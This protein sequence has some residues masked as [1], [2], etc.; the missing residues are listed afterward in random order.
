MKEALFLKRNKER[1]L[2]YEKALY[3]IEQVPADTLSQMYIALTD[4]LAYAQTY[5]PKSKSTRYLNHLAAQIHQY[6]YRNKKEKNNR[7]ATFWLQELPLV[8]REAQPYFFIAFLIFTVAG[9][10]GALSA[11]Y[12]ERFI[13]LIMGDGYVDM[14]LENIRKGNPMAVYGNSSE[15]TMFLTITLNNILV[16]FKAFAWGGVVGG[17]PLFLF[18]SFGTGYILLSNGIML[19]SFFYFLYEQ[20]VLWEAS[21]VIWLHGTIE[22]SVIV[23][24]GGAGILMGNKLMFPGTYSRLE[25]FKQGARQGV[26]IIIGLV[27]FFIVAGFIES[28]IT[29]YTQ[30][31]LLLKLLIIGLSF[32]SVLYYF[33]LYPY[34]LH[35]RLSNEKIKN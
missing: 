30:M 19:G 32:A 33:I 1:W 6:I 7:F 28:F 10:I 20:G 3:S 34:I 8:F 22:I 27:P 31:P 11:A 29:R 16:S 9:G 23:L 15:L 35:R 21:A 25:A 12:D 5:Y 17:I 18:L 13:R 14:T 2:S 24:A 26:K 4:D